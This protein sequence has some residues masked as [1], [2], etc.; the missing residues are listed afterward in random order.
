MWCFLFSEG[1]SNKEV[2]A[3]M[4]LGCIILICAVLF[5]PLGSSG[6]LFDKAKQGVISY[7]VA[8]NEQKAKKE[9]STSI[10]GYSLVK[11]YHLV[12]AD[13]KKDQAYYYG[14]QAAIFKGKNNY[15]LSYKA[16]GKVKRMSFKKWSDGNCG[17]IIVEDGKIIRF[18]GVYPEQ[19][20]CE[21]G[22]C[23]N[24]YYCDFYFGRK[25]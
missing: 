13:T 11:C 7:Q 12:V 19:G 21:F 10:E 8:Y 25:L 9:V 20:G 16:D 6:S 15:L 5:M 14:Q 23:R 18:A 22:F 1:A 24:G 2:I 4:V 3:S 17:G